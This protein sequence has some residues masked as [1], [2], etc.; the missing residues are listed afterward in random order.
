MQTFQL[1]SDGKALYWLYALQ[2][3]ETVTHPVTAEK[4]KQHPLILHTLDFKVR[5]RGREGEREGGRGREGG[6]CLIDSIIGGYV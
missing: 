1:L 3:Q 5:E 6:R 2:T 4:I